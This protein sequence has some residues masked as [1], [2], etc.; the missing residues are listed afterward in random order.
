VIALYPE[1]VSGRLAVPREKWIPLY[2]GP[3]PVEDDD[4]K[5]MASTDTKDK[6]SHEKSAADLLDVVAESGSALKSRLQKSALGMFVASNPVPKDDDTAS[7]I[8]SKRK[9]PLHGMGNYASAQKSI[10]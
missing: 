9:A 8:S 4:N 10:S 7:V 2:G 3:V 6:A 1:A 5:S